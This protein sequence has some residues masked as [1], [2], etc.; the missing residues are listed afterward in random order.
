MSDNNDAKHSQNGTD[1]KEGYDRKQDDLQQTSQTIPQ[2][3]KKK[4]N[5]STDSLKN[6]AKDTTAHKQQDYQH[7]CSYD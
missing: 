4:F 6:P 1:D 7:N 2:T 3:F 5:N